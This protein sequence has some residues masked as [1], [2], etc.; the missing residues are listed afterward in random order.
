MSGQG[1]RIEPIVTK[2]SDQQGKIRVFHLIKG[3]GVG[4]AE[5]LLSEGLAVADR[6]RFEFGFG[7]FLPWKDQLVET[8][9]SL[10]GEVTCFDAGSPLAMARSIPRVARFLKDWRAD[11][12][13]CHLPLSGV[14]GRLAGGRAGVPVIYTEHNLQ[15]RYHPAT[16]WANRLT[17]R[18][19]TRALAVSGEVE[20]SIQ[21]HLGDRVPVERVLNGIRVEAF[22]RNGAGP[23]TRR[24][25]GI[26]DTAPVVGTVAVFRRQKRLDQ[27][28][29]VAGRLGSTLPD[30][31]FLVVGDGPLRAEVEARAGR[32]G[33][34][35]HLVGFRDDVAPYLSAMDVFLMTSEHEGLPLALLEAMASELAVVA[36]GV[37]GIPEV[38]EDGRSGFLSASAESA[39][40]L[41]S[42][43][44][45]DRVL[46][47][48]IGGQ[49]RRRVAESFSMER[50][51]RALERIYLDVLADFAG[52]AAEFAAERSVESYS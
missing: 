29:D 11:L 39:V 38:I 27:W 21:R 50:M 8:L 14:V 25:L 1:G 15:E 12:V 42:R 47:D 6:G 36:T 3:L 13:H 17:W 46:R 30:L 34:R 10:G 48:R 32:L 28:F 22:S 51:A 7:Y 20:A 23:E 52:P 45:A 18:R 49:A 33:E 43:L 37:G 5:S 31:H 2:N 44:V 16:A 35:M 24:H 40:D 19:Q 41:V 4:G 26:P 9:E